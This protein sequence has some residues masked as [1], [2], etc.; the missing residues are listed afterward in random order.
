MEAPCSCAMCPLIVARWH[1]SRSVLSLSC[2]EFKL[3]CAA[4]YRI[5]QTLILSIVVVVLSHPWCRDNFF[6]YLS[7]MNHLLYSFSF[8]CALVSLF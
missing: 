7:T 5:L 8:G 4:V 6:N 1:E 2:K 3:Q